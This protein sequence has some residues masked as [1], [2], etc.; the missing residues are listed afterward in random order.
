MD[1]SVVY[2]S[3]VLLQIM[4]HKR[5]DKRREV[6]RNK[7]LVAY[8]NEQSGACVYCQEQMTLKLGS[9]KTATIDH[10]IP[11]S[12]GGKKREENEVAACSECNSI[13]SNRPPAIFMRVQTGY[14]QAL[15]E[16]EIDRNIIPFPTATPDEPRAS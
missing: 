2:G 13:K 7:R 10:V 1:A 3:V 15:K 6:K 14:L 12:K 5:K 8:F 11:R 9:P 16:E 4:G